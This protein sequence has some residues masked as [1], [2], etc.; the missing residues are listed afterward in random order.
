MTAGLSW[1]ALLARG[2]R[3]AHLAAVPRKTVEEFAR[4]LPPRRHA[5]VRIVRGKHCAG[6]T[7][8]FEEFAR[9]LDFPS[10]FGKNWDALEDCLTDLEWLSA[11]AFVV[12]VTNADMVLPS[13]AAEWKTCAAVLSGAA[14]HWRSAEESASFHVLFHCE[15]A[16]ADE[17][18][19]RLAGEGI[20]VT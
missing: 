5:A 8:L 9:A 15:P 4:T 11:E 14:A 2:P 7:E 10:Y 1:P 17:L 18:R 16:N 19:A 3:W 12:I 6:R 13:D 20:D